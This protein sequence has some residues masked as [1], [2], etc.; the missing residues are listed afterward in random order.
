M[1]TL[2]IAIGM[3]RS[4]PCDLATAQKDKVIGT[5]QSFDCGVFDQAEKSAGSSVCNFNSTI[6][7]TSGHRDTFIQMLSFSGTK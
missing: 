6:L 3:Y 7:M 2:L 5:P 4:S 1:D